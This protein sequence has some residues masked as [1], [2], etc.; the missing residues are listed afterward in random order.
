MARQQ[1]HMAAYGVLTARLPSSRTTRRPLPP[2]LAVFAATAKLEW[3]IIDLAK[4]VGQGDW[5][6]KTSALR[7]FTY[8]V[9]GV[10]HQAPSC[11]RSAGN[12][13][14]TEIYQKI[15]SSRS[16]SL[17][18]ISIQLVFGSKNFCLATSTTST[19]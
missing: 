7:S 16:V 18:F 14:L 13:V 12:I 1:P 15:I 19:H 17:R 2:L 4:L 10:E 9:A 3:Q 5:R 8:F 11:K 6:S